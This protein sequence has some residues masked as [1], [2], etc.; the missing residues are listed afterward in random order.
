MQQN[1]M[2]DATDAAGSTSA[3]RPTD[4]GEQRYSG[5]GGTIIREILRHRAH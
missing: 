2:A 5:I 3:T 1:I 4:A